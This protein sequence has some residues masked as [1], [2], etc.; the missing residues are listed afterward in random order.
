MEES[1]SGGLADCGENPGALSVHPHRRV[2]PVA[3]A[4]VHLIVGGGVH[5]DVGRRAG[6]AVEGASDR[7]PVGNVQIGVREAGDELVRRP[8]LPERVHQAASQLTLGSRD[9]VAKSH[10]DD[11]TGADDS[12]AASTGPLSLLPRPVP[13]SE[14]APR[15]SDAMPKVP[16]GV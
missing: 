8:S 6:K 9:D 7:I 13:R 11:A 4:T 3:L 14:V 16:I 10:P 15:S 12:P 5:Q 2:G 1:D